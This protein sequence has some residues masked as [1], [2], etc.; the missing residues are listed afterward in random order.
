MRIQRVS[1]FSKS[2]TS[3][4]VLIYIQISKVVVLEHFLL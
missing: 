1:Y 2:N 3:V 4:Y